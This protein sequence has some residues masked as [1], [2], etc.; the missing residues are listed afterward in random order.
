MVVS[1]TSSRILLNDRSPI[2]SM[3]DV[4]EVKG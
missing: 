2:V 3:R 4:A 1:A